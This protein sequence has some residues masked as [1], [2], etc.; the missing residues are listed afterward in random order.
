M[1]YARLVWIAKAIEYER[2]MNFESNKL[3]DFI[4]EF[5]C[6]RETK[7][8]E[9]ELELLFAEVQFRVNKELIP[10]SGKVSA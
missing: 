9:E 10:V 6:G 8:A 4:E 2:L 1:K 5:M 7:A 3:F